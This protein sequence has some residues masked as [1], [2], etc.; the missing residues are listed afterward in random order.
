MAIDAMARLGCA[1]ILRLIASH[2]DAREFNPSFPPIFPRFVQ[3]AIWSYCA[4]GG[5]NICNVGRLKLVLVIVEIQFVG[6]RLWHRP[7][8]AIG[9][10]PAIVSDSRFKLRAQL[11]LAQCW[12]DHRSP[13]PAP[14]PAPTSSVAMERGSRKAGTGWEHRHMQLFN[15]QW[16]ARPVAL[17]LFRAFTDGS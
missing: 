1:S 9:H 15:L 6:L 14:R 2:V 10:G 5:L 8:R 4:E 3:H 16:L 12:L 7:W 17:S 13:F 11:R